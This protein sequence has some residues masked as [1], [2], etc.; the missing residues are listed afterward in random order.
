M[1]G[2]Y[3]SKQLHSY[4]LLLLV[5][6]RVHSCVQLLVTSSWHSVGP[7]CL[8]LNNKSQIALVSYIYSIACK[9]VCMYIGMYR[10]L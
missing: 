2:V 5:S 7:L 1:F 6:L 8:K 9:D 3:P 4:E 10:R